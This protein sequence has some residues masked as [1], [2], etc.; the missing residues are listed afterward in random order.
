[1]EIFLNVPKSL[2][3][4]VLLGP[5]APGFIL[6]ALYGHQS[7]NFYQIRSDFTLCSIG[8]VAKS[9]VTS[10]IKPIG[11]DR[12]NDVTA[13]GILYTFFQVYKIR[14]EF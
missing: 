7:S 2:Q 9:D 11:L 6:M 14:E 4:K 3:D 5:P 10:N 13:F 12:S 1:M 8:F